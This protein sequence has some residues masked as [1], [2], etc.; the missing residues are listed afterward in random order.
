LEYF[1]AIWYNLWPFGIVN[2][3]GIFFPNL[4]C[5]DKEK[6]G[7][8]DSNSQSISICGRKTGRGRHRLFQI[9]KFFNVSLGI[10]NYN[11]ESGLPDG[12]IKNKKIPIWVNFRRALDLKMFRYFVAIWNILWRFGIFYDH[13][14]HFPGF[15]IM[16]QEKSGNPALNPRVGMHLRD[17]RDL[18]LGA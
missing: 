15:G 16:Y 10:T 12:L 8:P 3:F 1:T 2:G 14:V 5:L 4:V 11:F 17:G 9:N 6:S 18:K 13:L 7:N